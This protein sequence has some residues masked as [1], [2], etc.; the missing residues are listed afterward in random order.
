MSLKEGE[1]KSSVMSPFFESLHVFAEAF[2]TFFT[3]KGLVRK[4]ACPNSCTPGI[5]INKPYR[6]SA[7]ADGSP[8]HGGIRRNHTIYGLGSQQLR[9]GERQAATAQ[10]AS[11]LQQ[12]ALIDT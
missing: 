5:H 6:I 9:F 2:T 8:A 10:A 12:G 7:K 1:Y 4:S 3:G 11:I